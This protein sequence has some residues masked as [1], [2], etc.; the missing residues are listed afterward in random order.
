MKRYLTGI[1]WV[2]NSMDYIEKIQSGIGNVSQVVVELDGQ[3]DSGVLRESLRDFLKKFPVLYGLPSRNINLCP[4]WKV[5]SRGRD[6]QVRLNV[7]Q[8]GDA[9]DPLPLLEAEINKPFADDR[10]LL[11]FTLVNAGPKSFLGMTFDHRILDARGA[12]T[13]LDYFQRYYQKKN[14]PDI[15]LGESPHLDQ[16]KEKF[17][18]GRQVNRM[19]LGLAKETSRSLPASSK[20]RACKLKTV[21]LDLDQASLFIENAYAKAGY[22][23]LMPY[24]L[25]RSVQLMHRIFE[26]R[27]IPGRAY[28][29]PLSI[30]S[31]LR[32]ASGDQLFFNHLS[33]LFFKIDAD[34]AGNFTLL[35]ASI[36]EQMYAQVKAGLPE[37]IKRA[38]FLLRIAPLPLVN[39]FLKFLSQKNFSSFVFSFVNSVYNSK[40]F[41]EQAV[42]NMFHLPRVPNPPGVGI[43]FNQF[44]GVLNITLSYL[45]GVLSEEEADSIG[46]AF[47]DIGNES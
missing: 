28:L 24:A 11:V 2:I 7:A 13:L 16:W 26:V 34:V 12:E 18:A 36:K 19:F 46:G 9:D 35:L 8:I 44:K 20:S 31:R 27:N 10:E 3:L 22:L 45:E 29:I 43:F 6:A 33:F 1:D 47:K 25:A 39:F 21:H 15:S 14:I 5:F 38:S 4:Y 32:E 23:M 30:D 37:A 42:R 41:M 17:K 40:G